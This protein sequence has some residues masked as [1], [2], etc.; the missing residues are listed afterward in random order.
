LI[1]RFSSVLFHETFQLRMT[2][3]RNNSSLFLLLVFNPRDIYFSWVLKIIITFLLL[4]L[5]NYTPKG[6]KI[7]IIARHQQ[8]T[9][10]LV[11]AGVP[12]TKEPVSLTRRDSKRPDG[13]T[14][15]PWRSGKLLVWDVSWIHALDIDRAAEFHILRA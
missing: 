8:L 14:Q 5:G 15:L 11:S 3:T 2:P 4:T 12:A 1:Q 13:T 7:I 9:R 6:I 10:A